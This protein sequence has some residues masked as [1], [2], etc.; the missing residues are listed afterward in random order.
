MLILADG[1]PEKTTAVEPGVF[2]EAARKKLR[3]YVEYP[4]ALPDVQVGPPKEDQAG[5]RRGRSPT[6]SANRCGR[7][8]S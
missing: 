3:L 2:D 5:A 1:Y 8:G 7:C 4:A 6:S